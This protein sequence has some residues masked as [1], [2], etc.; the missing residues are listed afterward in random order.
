[1]ELAEPEIKKGS[2]SV[3]GVRDGFSERQYFT[4][5]T[6]SRKITK[7]VKDLTEALEILSDH[8][9]TDGGNA[10][11]SYADLAKQCEVGAIKNLKM[12]A[13]P[14]KEGR[15]SAHFSAGNVTVAISSQVDYHAAAGSFDITDRELKRSALNI[16]DVSLARNMSRDDDQFLYQEHPNCSGSLRE[17]T[18]RSLAKYVSHY[19][20]PPSMSYGFS[21]MADILRGAGAHTQRE[22]RVARGYHT[23]IPAFNEHDQLNE[24][25]LFAMLRFHNLYT[26]FLRRHVQ[27]ET[28]HDVALTN[29]AYGGGNR[30]HT[31]YRNRPTDLCFYSDTPTPSATKNIL[32]SLKDNGHLD[33]RTQIGIHHT[34]GCGDVNSST[35]AR[36]NIVNV[37][38][39]LKENCDDEKS[40][41]ED[42][43]LLWKIAEGAFVSIAMRLRGLLKLHT[44]TTRQD[45]LTREASLALDLKAGKNAMIVAR[46][47]HKDT[48]M[49]N[50][51]SV[52]GLRELG[53]HVAVFDEEVQRAKYGI[54]PVPES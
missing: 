34:I 4:I 53:M 40:K 26:A 32:Q 20:L 15:V 18:G 50:E 1:M 24:S 11:N 19:G 14:S 23:S 5:H 51:V 45:N 16:T 44:Q 21:E 35:L 30:M 42:S 3:V 39:W 38:K 13:R 28:F 43:E 49:M 31:V 25:I 17:D 41:R 8:N 46:S 9:S 47:L 52:V 37:R 10:A 48:S 2:I 6:S 33:D 54:S 12:D 29:G 22:Y 7:K 36:A 27:R